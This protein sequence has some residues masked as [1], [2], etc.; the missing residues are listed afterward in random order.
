MQSEKKYSLVS[1][2]MPYLF[3]NFDKYT[4]QCYHQGKVEKRYKGTC[5]LVFI[6]FFFANI[7]L[8]QNKEKMK[9]LWNDFL[10]I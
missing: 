7:K 9:Y 6:S 1:I 2:F 5:C 10:L 3:L 8:L 4:I